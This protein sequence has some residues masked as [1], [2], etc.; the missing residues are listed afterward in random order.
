M[1]YAM[2]LR[3]LL[4]RPPVSLAISASAG[5]GEGCFARRF[6]A[7]GRRGRGRGA[8]AVPVLRLSKGGVGSAEA[9]SAAAAEGSSGRC[10][11]Q[12]HAKLGERDQQEWLSGERFLTDCKR[13]ESPFLTRRERFR[14]EFM[15][16]VVPWEKGNLTWQNFPYYVK[17]DARTT[18]SV[19][20]LSESHQFSNDEKLRF[21]LILDRK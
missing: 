21:Y 2:R 18:C 11:E 3:C 8:A 16:R 13:R 12:E 10:S 17:Y 5:G 19:L 7:A 1:Y 14:N 4:T 6:G 20:C 15:R 9:R